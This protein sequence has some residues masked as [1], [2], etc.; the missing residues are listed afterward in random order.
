MFRTGSISNKYLCMSDSNRLI[1][2]IKEINSDTL[3]DNPQSL[4]THMDKEDYL[5]IE[6]YILDR[7]NTRDGGPSI[8]NYQ[9]TRFHFDE[10]LMKGTFRLTFTIERRF[11]CSDVESCSNDYL[12]F[13]FSFQ[14]NNM[15]ATTE[16]VEWTL[17]N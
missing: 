5:W 6:E 12:D 4:L 7:L 9:I 11:C 13:D 15:I 2:Q 8:T 14:N 16:Y 17:N 3:K 1:L 10:P